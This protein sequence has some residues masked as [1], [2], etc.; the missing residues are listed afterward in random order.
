VL[1][2]LQDKEERAKMELTK[3]EAESMASVR[4]AES[5]YNLAR[6]K[7]RYARDLYQRNA[8]GKE[9]YEI[10][11]QEE[12][13]ARLSLEEVKVGHRLA[14]L[15]YRQAEAAVRTREIVS[16]HEGIVVQIVRRPG[17][18]VSALPRDPILRRPGEAGSTLPKDP[19]FRV[20]NVEVLRVTGYLDA[21][22]TWRVHPGQSVRVTAEMAGPALP[23]QSEVFTGQVI[24]V[25]SEIDPRTRTCRVVAE[26]KNRKGLLRAGLDVQM[27]ILL[28]TATPANT[29]AR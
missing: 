20:V 24:F 23:I 2:R 15:R 17:E 18:A 28:A 11:K 10:A 29:A 25:D 4:T 12:E 8:I 3:F 1:G 5:K 13:T 16:P 6:T 9:E 27:E 21:G 22:D 14:E 19:I 26:V 7:H